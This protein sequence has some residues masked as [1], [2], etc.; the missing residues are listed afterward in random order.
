MCVLTLSMTLFSSSPAELL[1]LLLHTQS[2]VSCT[3]RGGG[4]GGGEEEE[5]GK[6]EEEGEEG[7]GGEGGGGGGGGGRRRGKE[8]V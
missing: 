4:G 5:V 7:G 1:S 6:E 3:C 2:W 8:G